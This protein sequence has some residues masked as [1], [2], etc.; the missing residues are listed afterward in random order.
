LGLIKIPP[1]MEENFFLYPQALSIHYYSALILTALFSLHIAAALYHRLI[2]K[3]KYGVW[4]RMSF[5]R[6]KV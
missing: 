6:N 5:G 1:L 3:D 2:I 4:R